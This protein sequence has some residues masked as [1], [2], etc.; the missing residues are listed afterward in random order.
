MDLKSKLKH[1]DPIGCIL[2]T[3]SITCLLLA[4]QWA[5]Q[6]KAWSDPTIIGLFVGC[7][8]LFLLFCFI[9]WK[10]GDK[11]TIPL[12]VL[13]TRSIWTGAAVLFFLGATTA[14]VRPITHLS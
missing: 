8:V 3:A 10:R 11:A 9:Q 12:R 6:S 4:L 2:F 13:F 14:I 5:G 7:S 1:L